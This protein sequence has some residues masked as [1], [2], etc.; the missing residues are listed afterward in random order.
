MAS[1]F[2][3]KSKPSKKSSISSGK[4]TKLHGVTTQKLISF[5][6]TAVRTSNPTCVVSLFSSL[7]FISVLNLC[8]LKC[9]K[10]MWVSLL[11]GIE[12]S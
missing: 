5:I 11:K 12:L 8:S 9:E 6:M 1:I 3:G 2:K 10:L 7:S 4:H